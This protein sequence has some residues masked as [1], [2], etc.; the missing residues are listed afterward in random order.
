MGHHVITEVVTDSLERLGWSADVLDCMS[1][2][3]R[4]GS[5]IGDW[6]FRRLTGTPTL[7]DGLH[8]SHFRPGSSVANA[9]DRA[10]TKRL[11]PALRRHLVLNPSDLVVSTF[12]TG[13]SAMAKLT[14]AP[15]DH[16]P[17]TVGM[18]TDVSP[19]RLWVWE[20]LDLFLVTSPAAAAAVRRYVPRAPIV[21]VPQPVRPAFY[22]APEQRVARAGL[23][24]DADARCVL[25]MGGGWGLGPLAETAR[26]LARQGVVVLAVA[27]R[28]RHLVDALAAVARD[29]PGVVP[30]GFSDEVP[31]LMAAAD[32]IVTTPGATTC[33]EARVVGRPLVL[34][35][36]VPGH[37][38][39]N[40][41]HEL[42]LD[43]A[44]VCDP[45]PPR[46]VASVLAALD[47]AVRPAPCTAAIDR[48]DEHFAEALSVVGILPGATSFQSSA[49]GPRSTVTGVRARGA[50]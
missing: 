13:A 3:G 46:L 14:A 7:Y 32:V 5:K 9:V 43:Q 35:D 21:V 24:I 8:F 23:G 4:F 19:H 33:S 26:T 20:G 15:M 17:A 42:E 31:K 50:S 34:L 27:G 18:C 41:Q 40:V 38:R 16:R 2:L 10:A 30:F 39:D 36:V 44:D 45:D 28:N 48:W 25:V 12:A 49:T 37:G 6:V 29:Q 22:T 1:L 47:R 11:V